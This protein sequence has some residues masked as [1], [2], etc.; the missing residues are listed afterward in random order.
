M[1]KAFGCHVCDEMFFQD[2]CVYYCDLQVWRGR[3]N[4]IWEYGQSILMSDEPSPT[5]H[6]SGFWLLALRTLC[7]VPTYTNP[8]IYIVTSSSPCRPDRGCAALLR[9]R[10]QPNSSLNAPMIITMILTDTRVT[11]SHRPRTAEF[12][13]HSGLLR[14]P[15]HPVSSLSPGLQTDATSSSFP[16][17]VTPLLVTLEGW[18]CRCPSI[19]VFLFI[20]QPPPPITDKTRKW[21]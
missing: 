16:N 2:G 12:I 13:R 15:V 4:G 5:G 6:A 1:S 7:K 21:L 20:K 14:T 19:A 11:P 18:L 3:W 17:H 10:M 9:R 8:R